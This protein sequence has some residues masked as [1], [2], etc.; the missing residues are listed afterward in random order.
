M[1]LLMALDETRNIH[2]SAEET[3]MSQPAASKMLKDIEGVFGVPLFDRLPRGIRPTEYGEAVIRHVRMALACLAQAQESVATLQAGLSGKVSVGAIITP[4][5]SLVPQA[6]IRTK[7]EAP[8]LNISFEVSTS[9]ELVADLK[10]GQV[11]FVLGRIPEQ[12]DQPSLLYEEI[13]REVRCV[14]ARVGHPLMTRSDLNLSDLAR[15]GWI[16]SARGTILHNRIDMMFRTAGLDLPSNTVETTSVLVVMNMLMHTDFLHAVPVDVASFYMRTGEIAMLPINIPCAVENYG[17]ISRRDAI[18]SPG[19]LLL[20]R[21][22]REVAAEIFE[23][24]PSAPTTEPF[25]RF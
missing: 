12:E 13:S 17:I 8:N 24:E 5:P 16:L 20:L 21:H 2:R 23:L 18:A 15:F 19:A 11:D 25:P 14:V 10:R 22:V 6:I 1:T 3:G 7:R 9:N 4:C